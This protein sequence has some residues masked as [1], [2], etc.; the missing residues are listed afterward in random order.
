METLIATAVQVCSITVTGGS[1]EEQGACAQG[2]PCWTGHT[3]STPSPPP[4]L[5]HWQHVIMD[6]I[7]STAVFFSC[8]KLLGNL[9]HA[10][11]SSVSGLAA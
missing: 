5:F 9:L 4:T 11:A 1:K 8:F 10:S 2:R 3:S 6:L 7:L